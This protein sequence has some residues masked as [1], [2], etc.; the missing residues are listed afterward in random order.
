[1]DCDTTCDACDACDACDTCDTSHTTIT[2]NVELGPDVLSSTDEVALYCL[3]AYTPT[4]RRKPT[5]LF[6]FTSLHAY[7]AYRDKAYNLHNHTTYSQ[8]PFMT[9]KKA[10]KQLKLAA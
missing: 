4:S 8:Q 10:V 7:K 2:L 5:H 3:Q 1:M 9:F 6:S